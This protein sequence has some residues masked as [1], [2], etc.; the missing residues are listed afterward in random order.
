MVGVPFWKAAQEP[1]DPESVKL[2]LKSSAGAL[3][4]PPTASAFPPGS[5]APAMLVPRE[6]AW[7]GP[8]AGT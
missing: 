4:R 3:L 8:R 5:D 2:P 6:P 1:Q 7:Q